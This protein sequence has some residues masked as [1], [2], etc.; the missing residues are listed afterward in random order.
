MVGGLIHR[1]RRPEQWRMQLESRY[2]DL[3]KSALIEP[4][5]NCIDVGAHIG[6]M[7]DRF[8][9]LTPGGAH[10]AI[11]P[12]PD[13]AAWLRWRFPDVTVR[14]V[15]TSDRDGTAIFDDCGHGGG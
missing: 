3:A 11:E 14:Q 9:R 7:T 4:G 5:W 13:K 1:W 8:R 2:I 6:S 15:A 10:L 12:A